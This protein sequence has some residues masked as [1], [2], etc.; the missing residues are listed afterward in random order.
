VGDHF[1]LLNRGKVIGDYRKGSV[2]REE[3]VRQMAGGAELEQLTH[4]LEGLTEVE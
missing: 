2:T 4:E 3:L 1:I